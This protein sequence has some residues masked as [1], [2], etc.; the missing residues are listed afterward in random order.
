VS[1]SGDEPEYAG[2]FAGPVALC[3]F[4][5]LGAPVNCVS[6]AL[7]IVGGMVS[8]RCPIGHSFLW[9][10]PDSDPIIILSERVPNPLGEVVFNFP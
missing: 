10:I 8:M 4:R 3:L 6:I 7:V 1:I 9:S 2:L 5:A